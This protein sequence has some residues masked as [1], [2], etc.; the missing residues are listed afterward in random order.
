MGMTNVKRTRIA[1]GY[2]AMDL[3]RQAVQW[4]DEQRRKPGKE[5]FSPEWYEKIKKFL[6]DPRKMEP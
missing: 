5:T 2:I 3:C 4:V 1:S 6:A